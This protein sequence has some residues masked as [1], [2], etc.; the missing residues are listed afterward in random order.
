M[1]TED[2]HQA[3]IEEMARERMAEI[4]SSEVPDFIKAMELNELGMSREE[5]IDHLGQEACD[6]GL[7]L[8]TLVE[9]ISDMALPLIG[10]VA[11]AKFHEAGI[12]NDDLQSYLFDQILFP[13]LMN[14]H[15]RATIET[16]DQ[17]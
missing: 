1:T 16:E 17:E 13:G 10:T 5:I 6:T 12:D 14:A 11:T 4:L 7:G 2:D 9:E 15:F 8:A 3:R